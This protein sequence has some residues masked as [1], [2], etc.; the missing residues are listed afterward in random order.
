MKRSLLLGLVCTLSLAGVSE[1]RAALILRWAM[2]NPTPLDDSA[3]TNDLVPPGGSANPTHLPTGGVLGGGAYSFDGA[4]DYFSPTVSPFVPGTFGTNWTISYWIKT[5][6][7]GTSSPYAGSPHVPVL[8]DASGGIVFGVGLHGGKPVFWHY[9]GAGPFGGWVH[10]DGATNV[11]DG[12]GNYVTYVHHSTGLLD[13]YVNGM[14]DTLGMSFMDTAT[15]YNIRDIGRTYNGGAGLFATMVLDDVRIYN[16]ALSANEILLAFGPPVP[17][18]SSL[19]LVGLGSLG[20]AIRS[21]RR[22]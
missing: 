3:G 16:T 9:T 7:T 17:E 11:A 20:L 22:R 14:P 10:A 18:P 12:I 4:N 8:G 5:T 19:A 1:G 15:A 6:D 21:R 13:I 2:D